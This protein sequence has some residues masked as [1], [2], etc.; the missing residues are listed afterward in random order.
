LFTYTPYRALSEEPVQVDVCAWPPK[1]LKEF[2]FVDVTPALLL[3]GLH[4]VFVTY[5]RPVLYN[6][7]IATSHINT[8]AEVYMKYSKSRSYK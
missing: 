1:K 4:N 5:C 7:C 3:S 8:A 6:G 2:H